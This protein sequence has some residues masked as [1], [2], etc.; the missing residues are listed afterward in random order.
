M[1]SSDLLLSSLGTSLVVQWLRLR[2][3][4]VGGAG[5][6]PGAKIPHAVRCGQKTKTNKKT[7]SFMLCPG[8]LIPRI[9]FFF[10]FVI[11]GEILRGKENKVNNLL[12]LTRKQSGFLQ[13][14]VIYLRES[15]P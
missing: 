5:L 12:Y 1:C 3:S 4:N 11:L 2:A 10:F 8:C 13:P 9:L 7:L 14:C 15:Y 6:I